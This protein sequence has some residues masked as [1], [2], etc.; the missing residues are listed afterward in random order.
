MIDFIIIAVLAVMITAI[1]RYLYRAKKNGAVCIGC[2]S[3]CHCG[4]GQSG[5]CGGHCGDCQH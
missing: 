1:I 3:G 2:P 5:G 4:Q